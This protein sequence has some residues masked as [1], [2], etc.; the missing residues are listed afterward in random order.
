[1][2]TAASIVALICAFVTAY[3]AAQNVIDRAFGVTEERTK[4]FWQS[5]FGSL[6]FGTYSSW[7]IGDLLMS[8]IVGASINLFSI[9]V[10]CGILLYRR[11]PLRS[12][13]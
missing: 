13:C 11:C 4:L 3:P 6:I 7:I 1:M 9:M 2:E 8:P 12:T 5:F 10:W